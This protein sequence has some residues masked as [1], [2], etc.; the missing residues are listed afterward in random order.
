MCVF[1]YHAFIYFLRPPPW[2]GT[3]T[4]HNIGNCHGTTEIVNAKLNAKVSK[5]IS[6]RDIITRITVCA[7]WVHIAIYTSYYM[8]GYVLRCNVVSY[9]S[10]APRNDTIFAEFIHRNKTEIKLSSN[11][12][13]ELLQVQDTPR[14]KKCTKKPRQPPLPPQLEALLLCAAIAHMIFRLLDLPPYPPLFVGW[15]EF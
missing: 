14:E 10:E 4:L 7:S 8:Y 2:Y 15:K 3:V 12:A 9:F 13:L 1:K 5:T 11:R 6:L